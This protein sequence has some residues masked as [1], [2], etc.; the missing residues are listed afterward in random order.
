V[1][2]SNEYSDS[3]PSNANKKEKQ[4]AQHIKLKTPVKKIRQ[5]KSIAKTKKN[6]YK[7]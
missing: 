5:M 1:D 7:R 3:T 2:E 6:H 4:L